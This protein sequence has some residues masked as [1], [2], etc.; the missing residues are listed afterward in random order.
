M[1]LKSFSP[2]SIAELHII[3][4]SFHPANDPCTPP[5]PFSAASKIRNRILKSICST[6]WVSPSGFLKW[7]V[8][9]SFPRRIL[10]CIDADFAI[11]GSFCSISKLCK[12]ISTSLQNLRISRTSAPFLERSAQLRQNSRRE[13]DVCNVCSNVH[14]TASRKREFATLTVR[15]LFTDSV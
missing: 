12:I 6:V 10:G 5:S 8:F 9:S 1:I 4:L 2:R 7:C 13:A 15:D 11:E 3:A 14:T